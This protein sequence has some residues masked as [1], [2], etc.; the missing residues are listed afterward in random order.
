[1]GKKVLLMCS[2]PLAA[3]KCDRNCLDEQGTPACVRACSAGALTFA[4]VD[5][6]SEGR[7]KEF[8]RNIQL[9]PCQRLQGFFCYC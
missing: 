7:R 9:K 6:F 4:S 8:L 5:D 3:V 2:Y 1:M